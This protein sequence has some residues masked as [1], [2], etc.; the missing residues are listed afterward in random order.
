MSFAQPLRIQVLLEAIDKARGPLMRVGQAGKVTAKDLR[1]TLDELRKL[2]TQQDALS[3]FQ[4]TQ[5][6]LK[7]TSEQLATMRQR[8]QELRAAGHDRTALLGPNYAKN[9]AQAEREAGRLTQQL[10]AQANTVRDLKGRLAALGI[11]QV[12]GAEKRLADAMA[13]TNGQADTQR[14]RLRALTEAEKRLQDTR[15]RA[16]QLAAAGVGATAAGA[17]ALGPVGKVVKDYASLE[18]AML[19]VPKQVNGARGPNGEL[20]QNYYDI[21]KQ[22]FELSQQLP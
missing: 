10:A 13:R 18:T 20:T 9:L 22:V 19:G 15:Q 21:R 1:G 3:K 2:K 4:E 6:A 8:V 17:A 5:A 12:T 14:A 11:D 16:G 7:G